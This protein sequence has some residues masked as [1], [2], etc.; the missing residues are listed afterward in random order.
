MKDL[1][2]NSITALLCSR[3]AVFAELR[4]CTFLLLCLFCLLFFNCVA[5]RPYF[6][7]GFEAIFLVAEAPIAN[8]HDSRLQPTGNAKHSKYSQSCVPTS[9]KPRQ[10]T[11]VQ[12]SMNFTF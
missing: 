8:H 5:H 1:Y 10:K 4:V 12:H 2:V 6:S 7:A 9:G 11:A 3:L